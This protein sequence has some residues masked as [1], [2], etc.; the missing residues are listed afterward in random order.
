V[1]YAILGGVLLVFAVVGFLTGAGQWL[2]YLHLALGLGLVSYAGLTSFSELR[3]LAARDASR[4]G[5]RLGSN[6]FVQLLA[7]AVILGG[8]AFLSVRYAVQWDWTEAELHTLS[9]ATLDVLEQI[10]E[11]GSVEVY[12]F[13]TEGSDV[14]ARALLEMYDYAS[15]RF[16]FEIFDPNRFPEVA[17][18]FEV[19]QDGILFVCGG[20]CESAEGTVR[21][22]E[23]SEEQVT[24]AIRS[25]ISEQKKAY[26]LAGHGE[27]SIEDEQ[28]TGVS[29]IKGAMEA[30]NLVVAPLLLANLD[31]V[32]DD[33]DAVVVAGPTHSI[34]DRELEALDRYLQRGGSVALLVDP[35]VVTNVEARVRE[36]GIELGDDVVVDRTIDLF[37]GPRIGVQPVVSD[38]GD[39]PITEDL[40]NGSTL[41]QMARSVRAADGADVVEL[42]RTGP[43]SWA[44]SD[45]ERFSNERVVELN[46]GEDQAGPIPI[47]VART[48]TVEGEGQ[49]EGRLVVVGD[50]DFARNR[51][52]AKVYNADFFLNIANWL[53]GEE[54]FITIDRKVP[55]AS[56]AQLTREQFATFRYVALFFLPEGILLIG[57]L[58]WWR[59]RS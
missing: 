26:F 23:L 5:A 43:G 11:D 10:P 8:I 19:A 53:V 55:R 38:F 22:I 46:E 42:A 12:G 54:Q 27:A 30:E 32:P 2:S 18:R 33:A 6:A 52:V 29:R 24:R 58:I 25:S 47:A 39:H 35:I 57:I 13:F 21:V 56:M 37:A 51:H 3:E 48:F 40:E 44:E 31:E 20:P 41:F 17:A 36:W 45:L 50:A 15:E 59:R 34:L 14:A 4:R 1:I 7:L 16:G 28:A 49:R 9:G